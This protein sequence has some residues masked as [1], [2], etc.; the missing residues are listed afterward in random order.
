M[1]SS[2]MVSYNCS[3]SPSMAAITMLRKGIENRH[4]SFKDRRD[5]F[6]DSFLDQAKLLHE[7]VNLTEKRKYNKGSPP[8]MVNLQE[9]GHHSHL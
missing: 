1:S 8:A 4:T 3:I 7:S 5:R 2:L 6:L 9:G